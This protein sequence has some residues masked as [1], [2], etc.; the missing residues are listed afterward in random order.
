MPGAYFLGRGRVPGWT[1]ASATDVDGHP[2][3]R[4][5]WANFLYAC[6]QPHTAVL[7]SARIPHPPSVRTGHPLPG[8]GSVP[9][10][11]PFAHTSHMFQEIATDLRPPRNDIFFNEKAAALQAEFVKQLKPTYG[12]HHRSVFCNM[13]RFGKGSLV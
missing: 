13:Y 6:L 4:V 10:P 8:R 3:N 9:S 11:Q 2:E 1:D 5:P 7:A 12:F